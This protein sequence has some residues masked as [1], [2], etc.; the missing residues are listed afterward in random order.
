MYRTGNPSNRNREER[1]SRLPQSTSSVKTLIATG[2]RV[3]RLCD[4]EDS[5][6]KEYATEIVAMGNE[7]LA[8]RE[9]VETKIMER[10]TGY[11]GM[12][13]TEAQ[14]DDQIRITGY[15]IRMFDGENDCAPFDKVFP[16]GGYSRIIKAPRDRKRELVSRLITRIASLAPESSSLGAMNAALAAALQKHTEAVQAYGSSLLEEACGKACER[17]GKKKW[18][19]RYNAV[20]FR[21]CSDLGRRKANR[22][23]PVIRSSKRKAVEEESV[24]VTEAA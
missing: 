19:Q 24:A 16:D 20:Y 9:D 5:A 1:M 11:D 10:F 18:V 13:F 22:L 2:R 17:L 12:K 21:A 8:I 3:C 4:R 6:A 15:S 7:L 23:F 14:L